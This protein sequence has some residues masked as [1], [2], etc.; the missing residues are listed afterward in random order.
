MAFLRSPLP[1]DYLEPISAP[2][3]TLRAPGVSDYTAWA[4]VRA[5]SRSH[6][7]PWEPTWSRDELTRF[8]FRRRLRAYGQDARDDRGYYYFIVSNT[9]DT[10]IGGITLSNVRRGAA[11]CATLGYW[12]GAPYAGQGYMQRAVR[13]LSAFG[14]RNLRLHRIEAACMPTNKPSRRVLEKCGFEQE[15]LARRY[16]KINGAWEDHAIYALTEED[17]AL[18]GHA[19][20]TLP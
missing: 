10:L 6:L 5:L 14:F 7:V 2:T 16:L 18:N 20:G 15:G 8:S 19:W 12:I 3:V 17:G 4:Q 1:E 11:Q 9:N 13:M